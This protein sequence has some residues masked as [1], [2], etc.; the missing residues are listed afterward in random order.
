MALTEL[1]AN[2]HAEKMATYVSERGRAA[3]NFGSR[4]PIRYGAA[5]ELH[6]DILTDFE[7]YG[8]YIFEGVVD[9]D[10]IEEL[11]D[12]V[13]ETI[14]RAPSPPGSDTDAQG[15]PALGLDYPI[16]PYIFIKPLSDPWGGTKLL[17]GRHPVKMTEPSPDDD[18]PDHVVHL[19][20]QMCTSM[21]AA[22]RL[23]GH[24]D[25]LGIAEAI[26]GPNFVPYND[27]IFV[28]KP[29]MGGSVAWHQDGATHWDNPD[30]YP[31]IHGF[32]FQ[33]QLY[34]TTPAN[35]LWIVP[36]SHRK[37]RIDIKSRVADNEDGELL[38]DAIPLV[39]NAG[40]VT[41]VNRHM[42]HGSF[43]NTSPDPRVSITFGFYP[44][45]SV[46]GVSGGLNITL[47][48]DKS[49]EKIYDEEHIRRRSAVVQV[50]IDARHQ[51]RPEERRYRYAPF[52]G[53]EDDYRYGPETIESVLSDY[54]LYDIAL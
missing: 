13:E 37:G 27:S 8:F 14:E 30:W 41:I 6:P 2:Q 5:G 11:R 40:D 15:R 16:S 35:A 17:S 19:L 12:A 48:K 20:L 43:A 25:L 50:A 22:L 10:E 18:A 38:P 45:S 54:T 23:Y 4:G 51:A 3:A 39:A 1:S 52:L 46:L 47:D 31:G 7:N 21:P 26:N 36:G 24:P 53:D 28:K 29:G 44:H 49:G 33:V 42:L 9:I 32:N 34:P